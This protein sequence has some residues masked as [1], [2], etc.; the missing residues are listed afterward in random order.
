MTKNVALISPTYK[1]EV[2]FK[3]PISS[4]SFLEI[5]K[6]SSYYMIFSHHNIGQLKEGNSWTSLGYVNLEKGYLVRCFDHCPKDGDQ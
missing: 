3:I 2:L 1:K 4:E 5:A 6:E